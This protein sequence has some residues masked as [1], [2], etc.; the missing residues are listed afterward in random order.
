MFISVLRTIIAMKNYKEVP[1]EF[2]DEIKKEII[3][4]CNDTI[5]RKNFGIEIKDLNLRVI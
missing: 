1:S 3:E 5:L 4:E 2:G